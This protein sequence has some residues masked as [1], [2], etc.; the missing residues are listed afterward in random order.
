MNMM[1]KLKPLLIFLNFLFEM[2]IVN[3][4]WYQDRNNSTRPLLTKNLKETIKASKK[5]TLYWRIGATQKQ[6]R[7]KMLMSQPAG[8][9]LS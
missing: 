6:I 8:F 7:L 2:S 3:Q 5:S 4:Q 9:I 1:I